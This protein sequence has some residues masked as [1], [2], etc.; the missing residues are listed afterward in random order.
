MTPAQLQLLRRSFAAILPTADATAARF[1]DNLF[2]SNPPL[3][4]LF[5]G[6]LKA[7]R[8][9]FVQMIG[10]AVGL[11]D[12]PHVLLPMLRHLGARH[13]ADGVRPEHYGAVGTAL[14]ATLEQALGPAFDSET[15]TAWEMLYALVAGMMLEGGE[16]L[17]A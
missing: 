11:A 12:K 9:K 15:R 6:D 7:Q 14:I 10:G 16:A 1:Y 4:T 17:A 8:A 2:A 5:P 13:A 3:R